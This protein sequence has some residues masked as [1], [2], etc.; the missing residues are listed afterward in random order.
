M[1]TA[2]ALSTA[3]EPRVAGRE[4]GRRAL[5]QLAD[6][7]FALVITPADVDPDEL[8]AGLRE[9]L[10]ETPLFG[11]SAQAQVSNLG[12]TRGA[13]VVVLVKSSEVEASMAA[14]ARTGTVEADAAT[15]AAAMGGAPGAAPAAGLLL[16]PQIEQ[17]GYD[18]ARRLSEALDPPVAFSGGGVV[19]PPGVDRFSLAGSH[20]YCGDQMAREHAALLTLKPTSKDAVRFGFAFESCWSAVAPPVVVTR[21]DGN[22]ILE[23]DHT[24]VL[25]YVR[26]YL[27]VDF[28]RALETTA[29]KY[30]FLARLEDPAGDRYV[31][32]TPNWDGDGDGLSCYPRCDMDG[33]ELQLVQVSRSELLDGAT[34]AARRATVALGGYKPALGFLFS[35]Q[36]RRRFL[37]S[38][39]N[40][41]VAHI[42]QVLGDHVPLLG[43]Y[44]AGEFSPLYATPEEANDRDRPLWGSTGLSTSA[45]VML[46]GTR[47]GAPPDRDLPSLLRE[48]VERDRHIC[49]PEKHQ[50][51]RIE[52]LIRL[53][54][55]AEAMVDETENAFKHINRE[56]FQLAEKLRSRNRE[57][58]QANRRSERLQRI[59]RQYT[60]H[61]VWK[62]AHRSVDAGYYSIPDEELTPVLMF[63][64]VKGFT[65]YAEEHTSEEVIRELN[66][67]F[68]P[69]TAIIYD[70]D[71]DVD[72]FIGDCIFATFPEAT[73][74]LD[75]ALEIQALSRE[76]QSQGSPFTVRVGIHQGRVVSGNVGGAVRMDNTLIGDAVNLAQRLESACTPG[77][78]LLSA[79]VFRKI[80]EV[81]PLDLTPV[82]R[83]VQAKGKRKPVEA[84]E[85]T[86][87]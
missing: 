61:T 50:A 35:C 21:A 9:A 53:L 66:R 38:R 55:E 2:V 75:C 65:A 5:E 68:Q 84:Y 69:A 49:D 11:G 26:S 78:V 83:E 37:H 31:V 42:R 4:A 72:K 27:G 64:D 20:L 73:E 32:R 7:D 1:N 25:E 33:V 18:F 47:D 6:P 30:T 24:P 74:A 60:P 71:G 59:I 62:K 56:H 85:V 86:P 14:V 15:L 13:V 29:W 40:D 43:M 76:L 41:E 22:R 19:G 51:R 23:V 16:S 17:Q 81:L 39:A 58:A 3:P 79:D 46:V 10:G 67:I 52:E 48:H 28:Q 44:A 82:R 70:H 34:R 12:Q 54:D 36:L 8:H 77:S 57:L 45:C 63:M 87:P 80:R